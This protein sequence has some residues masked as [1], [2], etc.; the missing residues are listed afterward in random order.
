MEVNGNS[1]SYFLLG[2]SLDK[3]FD[4]L[5]NELAGELI[6][7]ICRYFFHD[8][9]ISSDNITIQALM[10]SIKD[11]LDDGKRKRDI[12]LARSEAGRKGGLAKKVIPTQNESKTEANTK[13]NESKCEANV[14]QNETNA[15]QTETKANQ[16]ETNGDITNNIIHNTN[17]KDILS[18]NEDMS[19]P[20]IDYVRF[21]SVFNSKATLLPRC[22]LMTEKRKQKLKARIEEF[23]KFSPSLE[24]LDVFTSLVERVQQS[25]F[26]TGNNA[27]GWKCSFDWLIE[28]S[29]NWV[30][31]IEGCYDN[32]KVV[33]P[34]S[35]E[36]FHLDG[37]VYPKEW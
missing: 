24:P 2:E 22:T 7:S 5:P 35:A 14:K 25:E 15:K 16:N 23:K 21:Q 31:V 6:K 8:E 18:S 10:Y 20:R 9:E 12:S 3:V 34:K 36:V 26:C 33:P 17:N 37:V 32:R 11:L 28:N 29:G 30:K 1:K 19:S 13:Q 27:Q 4:T